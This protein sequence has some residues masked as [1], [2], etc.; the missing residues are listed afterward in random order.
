MQLTRKYSKIPQLKQ[1]KP[2]IGQF[3]SAIFHTFLIASSTC[4]A[5]HAVWF[6]LVLAERKKILEE[7]DAQLTQR[8]QDLV[9][10]KANELRLLKK[11]W[12]QF[13]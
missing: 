12:Y 13:W 7:T 3:R 4:L 6:G 9:D 8:I 2:H 1:T 11:R 5:L 10:A